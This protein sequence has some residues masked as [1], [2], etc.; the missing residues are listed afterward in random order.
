M[1]IRIYILRKEVKRIIYKYK[2]NKERSYSGILALR[3]VVLRII[4][5]F[6]IFM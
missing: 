3:E 4:I 5:D 2:D 6:N 1:I